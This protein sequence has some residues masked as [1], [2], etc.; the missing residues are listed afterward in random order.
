MDYS[1]EILFKNVN[2]AIVWS[3]NLTPGPIYLEKTIIWSDMHPNVH[4]N[5]IYNVFDMEAI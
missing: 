1:M 3:S 5:T 2:R 4:G